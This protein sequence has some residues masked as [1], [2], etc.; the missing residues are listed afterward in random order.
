MITHP[1]SDWT[2][3][4][5]PIFTFGQLSLSVTVSVW[6]VVLP[7]I[8]LVGVPSSTIMVSSISSSISSLRVTCTFV[9]IVPA[10][11]VAVV[12]RSV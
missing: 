6:L 8:P 4:A 3:V 10:G 1:A 7:R 9:L 12:V 5:I 2:L 11:I